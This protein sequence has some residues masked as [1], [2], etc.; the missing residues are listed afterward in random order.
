MIILNRKINF[1]TTNIMIYQMSLS[2]VTFTNLSQGVHQRNIRTKFATNPCIGLRDGQKWVKQRS[3]I[4]RVHIGTEQTR[5]KVSGDF[6]NQIY[7]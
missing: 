3:I 1:S 4:K 7:E 2:Y 5:N 6:P